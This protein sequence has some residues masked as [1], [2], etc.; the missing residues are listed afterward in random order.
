MNETHKQYTLRQVPVDVDR[1]LRRRARE[2]GKSLN[3]VALE[4]LERGAGL[5][6]RE[7]RHHDLDRLVGSWVADPAFDA[8][9]EDMDRVD[10]EMWQ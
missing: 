2:E 4:A 8:A 6:P 3:R 1:E 9:V 5:G 7:I 10:G